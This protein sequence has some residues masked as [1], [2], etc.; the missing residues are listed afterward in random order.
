MNLFVID[1]L[2]K[3]NLRLPFS[4]YDPS[5][6]L[7][8]I[9]ERDTAVALRTILFNG[10]LKDMGVVQYLVLDHFAT[11]SVKVKTLQ[12]SDTSDL[13]YD[14]LFLFIFDG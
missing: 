14:S 2:R 12:R 11:F 13:D 7:E 1:C 8:L 3:A 10:P 5:Y 4:E 6:H 9:L